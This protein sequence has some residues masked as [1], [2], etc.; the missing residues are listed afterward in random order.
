MRLTLAALLLLAIPSGA[1]AAEWAR[2]RGPDGD[3]VSP[4]SKPVP[5]EW[6]ESK[7]L[8]WTAELP[9]PGLSSP[10]V[11]GDRVFLTSWTGYAAGE[12]SSDN[13][14]DLKRALVCIDRNSGET[15]WTKEV[16]AVQPEEP[17]R[18]M[19]AENGY[20][21]H[22]PVT[23][24]ER[25]FAFFGKTGVIAFDMDGEKLW[26]VSVG[27]GD[28][29]MGWGTSSSPVLYKGMVIITAAAE[30]KSII[31]LDQ[32]TG[33]EVWKQEADS[34]AGTWSTPILVE[35]P[36]GPELVLAVPY[37]IWGINPDT[38]KLRWYCESVDSNSA[39]ASPV[40]K[41]GVVYFV[42]GRDGGS[43]AVK[44]GGKGDVSDSHV[45]WR[46][47]HR[48]RIGSP[49][50]HGDN[51]Y[52]VANGVA[53]C[54]R[55]ADGAEVYQERL[56]S[57]SGGGRGRGQ[58][59]SS[60]VAADGKLFFVNRGGTC[61]VLALGDDFEQLAANRFDSDGGQYSATPAI[62][63]GQIFIRS[64]DRLYCVEQAVE[65]GG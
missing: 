58:D 38:G 16:A 29:M 45:V 48:A 54:I 44:I 49:V 11:H 65:A 30:S 18:G 35:G 25:V 3:G 56:N 27:V 62:V 7:N 37:E 60:M 12:G 5:T 17:F 4:D 52:W 59:Y 8:R 64:S 23:D 10:V 41:D 61:F 26:Q 20:A 1:D 46:E 43:I 55:L 39:C 28:G 63:D 36:E 13:I 19:F 22:T 24:G 53:N 6:S 21:S 42:G 9:G 34:L 14:D 2:F 32:K 15:I 57:G 47:R 31:A 50:A 40:V 51:L 33:E